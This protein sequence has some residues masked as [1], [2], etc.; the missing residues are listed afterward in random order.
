[1]VGIEIDIDAAANWSLLA[2]RLNL[3][4]EDNSPRAVVRVNYANH[5]GKCKLRLGDD[6]RAQIS[7]AGLDFLSET[8]GKSRWR[9]VLNK[10]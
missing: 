3:A 7:G 2:N 1:M 10:V 8:L 6:Y 5:R 4:A 9:L